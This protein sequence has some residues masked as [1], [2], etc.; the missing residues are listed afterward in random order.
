MQVGTCNKKE[1]V[2]ARSTILQL[3]AV[4]MKMEENIELQTDRELTTC[5]LYWTL[6]E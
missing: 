2:K 3:N 5:N 6:V 1:D 4:N